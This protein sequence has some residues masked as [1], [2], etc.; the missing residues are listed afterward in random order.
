MCDGVLVTCQV[1]ERFE[2]E[3][4]FE[5][6][7]TEADRARLMTEFLVA[8]EESCGHMCHHKKHSKKSR[9]QRRKSRSRSR[10]HSVSQCVNSHS[11]PFKL[12]SD[13]FNR[14]HLWHKELGFFH[15]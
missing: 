6:I 11:L 15:L 4:A 13:F 7:T 14:C 12:M 5:A 8:M 10:S 2:K 3:P 9:K 1:R